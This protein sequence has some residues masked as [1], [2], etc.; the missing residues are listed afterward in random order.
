M[1]GVLNESYTLFTGVSV[2]KR[3]RTNSSVSLELLRVTKRIDVTNHKFRGAV[4]HWNL[5]VLRIHGP[6][7]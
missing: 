4:V 2:F 1:S 5:K 6:L 3:S 7:T